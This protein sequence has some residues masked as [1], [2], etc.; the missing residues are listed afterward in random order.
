LLPYLYT[1]SYPFFWD[2]IQ[3]SSKH[4]SFFIDHLDTL[5]LPTE[6][7]SGHMP[8]FGYLLGLWWWVLGKTLVSSHMFML[9]ML[10]GVLTYSFKLSYLLV[11]DK[12]V[13]LWVCLMIEPAFITQS[14]LVSPDVMLMLGF[15]IF[16]YGLLSKTYIVGIGA[17]ILVSSSNRGFAVFAAIWTAHLIFIYLDR[18]DIKGFMVQILYCLPAVLVYFTYQYLHFQK[19]GWIGFHE[20][21]EWAPSFEK[22]D[23]VGIVKNILIMIWRFVDTGRVVVMLLCALIMIGLWKS[24]SEVSSKITPFKFYLL[25]LIIFLAIL[26]VP[27]AYLTGHRYYMPIYHLSILIVVGSVVDRFEWLKARLI[28]FGLI[29]TFIVGH[30]IVYPRGV[31]MGWDTTLACIPYQTLRIEMIEYI[32]SEGLAR[33]KIGSG[34]PNLS[35]SKFVDLNNKD[36]AFVAFDLRSNEYVLYSNVFNEMEVKDYEALEIEWEKLKS[37]VNGSVEMTLYQRRNKTIQR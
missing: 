28:L 15:Y 1:I 4:A 25:S 6:I 22:V 27:Y 33:D 3:L 20:S 36:D 29:F 30:F 11:K 18:K 24:N 23:G 10:V 12:A 17:L 32:D 26:T 7:D 35:S 34:F 13:W 5:F 8:L 21:M 31:A 16:L 37:L 9:P 14:T 19:F 2:T